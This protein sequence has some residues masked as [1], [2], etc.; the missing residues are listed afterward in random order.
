MVTSFLTPVLFL[1]AMGL[2][3]GALVDQ[4]GTA[5]LGGV[6]YVVFIAPGLLAFAAMQTGVAES[7]WPV[8]G[9]LKWVRTYHAQIAVAAHA[10]RRG[11][12]PLPLR[13]LPPPAGQRRPSSL[14]MAAVR[15]H[16]VVDWPCSPSLRQCSTGLAFA[17]PM[18][19]FAV[20]R[21]SEQGFSAIFRF[22]V[23]PL[24]LF[25]GTFFPITQ[26]PAA[27]PLDRLRHAAV[28]RRRPLPGPRPRH[29]RRAGRPRPRRRAR[30]PS[31]ASAWRWPSTATGGSS[32]PDVRALGHLGLV[33]RVAPPVLFGG[34]RAARL[35]ERNAMVYRR[36]WL[37]LV[38]GFFEPLF[39]LLSIGVGVGELV[40]DITLPDGR[41]IDYTAF[42]APALL[43]SS[44]MNG[45]VYDSTFNVFD[46]LKWKKIYDAVLATPLGAGDVA[47][48]E[49]TWALIRGLIYAAAFLIV[50]LAMGLVL[51]PW[52]VLALPA[53]VLIG[54]AFAGVRHGRHH[55]TCA[56]GST[57]SGSSW[58]SLPMFLFS[59]TFYPL[60]TYGPALQWVV[61]V[62]PLYQGVALLRGLTTGD[63]GPELVVHVVY[64]VTM[65]LIGLSIASRRLERLLLRCSAAPTGR[66][67]LPRRPGTTTRQSPA[68]WSARPRCPRRTCTAGGRCR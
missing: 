11:R 63:V 31:P 37:I 21:E 1:A 8:L 5:D 13:H 20:A 47:L 56:P 29:H 54:F 6:E 66:P 25:S 9:N 59:A 58:R 4:N 51:S 49:I 17:T 3:L 32:R 42:V 39:Y 50:M 41:I 34:R 30:S 27:A 26:L 28:A 15:R 64:L 23:T 10:G 60:S 12:R 48:G 44:A 7:S 36:I 61:R 14:V 16:R 68:R 35:V 57:S 19:A 18:T 52:A 65:G 43:A 62:T 46:K 45:A 22:V 38:S 33:P 53:A 55:A 40:G 2:G 24:F 67:R